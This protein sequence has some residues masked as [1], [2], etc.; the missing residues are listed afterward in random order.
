MTQTIFIQNVW[1]GYGDPVEETREA[2]LNFLRKHLDIEA[3]NYLLLDIKKAGEAKS[4]GNE[5]LFAPLRKMIS[6]MLDRDFQFMVYEETSRALRTA[7]KIFPW[8]NN[9]IMRLKGDQGI[10]EEK[11]T[12]AKRLQ[13]VQQALAERLMMFTANEMKQMGTRLENLCDRLI[14]RLEKN[15][16]DYL[17]RAPTVTQKLLEKKISIEMGSLNRNLS[18]EVRN[19]LDSFQKALLQEAENCKANIASSKKAVKIDELQV[20]LGGDFG[21][22]LALVLKRIMKAFATIV[23]GYWGAEGGAIIGSMIAPVIGTMIGGLIGGFGGAWIA[24]KLT[25]WGFKI[26]EMKIKKKHRKKVAEAMKNQIPQAKKKGKKQIMKIVKD[27]E[28]MVATWIEDHIAS[29]KHHL[30]SQKDSTSLTPKDMKK[31]LEILTED[32]KN[33]KKTIRVL[34]SVMQDYEEAA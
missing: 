9:E 18:R 16:I 24:N 17:N 25:A 3:P 22:S 11:L 20:D 29:E 23:G 7:K 8:L 10:L 21:A 2:N 34:G 13:K 31:R 4:S 5:K 27:I 19:L 26:P 14:D 12:E 15:V 33:L 30:T 6:P 1:G 32:Q 28:K